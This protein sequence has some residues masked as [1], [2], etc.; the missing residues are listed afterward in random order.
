[1]GVKK[2]KVLS[3]EQFAKKEAKRLK[4]IAKLEKK[5]NLKRGK[6]YGS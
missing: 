2:E 4:Q 1:M 6:M 3:A 5:Y